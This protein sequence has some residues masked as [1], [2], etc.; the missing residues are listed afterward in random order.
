MAI[1]KNKNSM[2]S[3]VYSN[4]RDA[5][6]ANLTENIKVKLAMRGTGL[7]CKERVL[8]SFLGRNSFVGEKFEK[9]SKEIET[10]RV[11]E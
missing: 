6:A 9:F 8:Q 3:A 4:C 5:G 10:L 11:D 1:K 7:I 2:G